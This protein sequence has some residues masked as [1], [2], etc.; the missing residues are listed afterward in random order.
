MRYEILANF[1]RGT[2][3]TRLKIIIVQKLIIFQICT[4]LFIMEPNYRVILKIPSYGQAKKLIKVNAK[5][6]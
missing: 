6:H 1:T 3:E 4:N 2:K 5:D